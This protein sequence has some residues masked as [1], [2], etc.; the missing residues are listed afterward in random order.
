[1]KRSLDKG[2]SLLE[3]LVALTVLAISLGV[4]VVSS[5][6]QAENSV[7]MRDR[8]LAHWVAMNVATTQ[9][10]MKKWPDPGVLEGHEEMAKREWFWT[11]QVVPTP[12]L[13]IRRLT[14]SVRQGKQKK[15]APLARLECYIGQ[16]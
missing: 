7:Y 15:S 8:V 9:M 3:V 2:F 16:P 13:T 5:G 10:V 11:I 14:I 1:M 12:E 6:R 4:M